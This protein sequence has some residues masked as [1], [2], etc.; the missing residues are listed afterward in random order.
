MVKDISDIEEIIVKTENNLP[1][2]IKDIAEVRFGKAIR[3]GAFTKNGEGKAVG[4]TVMMLKGF[5][6]NEVV[7]NVKAR[8]AEIQKTLPKGI[9]I[10][11]FLDRSSLI[12]DTTSTLK[13]NLAEG[14]LIVIFILILLL[15]NWRGG[16][17]VASTIPLSLLF[18]F[19]LMNMFG[20]S[21]NL[22]SLGA[23][24]FG[25]IV[26]GAVIIV[27]STVFLFHREILKK[28]TL[29]AEDR[30][31]ITTSASKKMMNSAFF[32]QIII[33]LVFVP[34]LFL[35]GIEGKMFRPM[36]FTFSFAMIGA[37]ILCLTYVPA[38]SALFLRAAKT[39]KK[40][41][42]DKIVLWLE[43]KY[44]KGLNTA[45]KQSKLILLSALVALGFSAFVF[46]KMGGEFIPQLDEGDIAFHIILQ[47][48]SSLEEATKAS[49]EVEKTILENFPEVT[50]VLC[51]FGVSEVP[52][53][54]M[55]MDL[56][57]C[58]AIL[59][60]KNEW[61]SADSK[62][63]L[64]NKI[65][66]K[67]NKIPG[68]SYEFTQPI[69]MRFNELISGVREDIAIKLYG[70][71]LDILAQKGQEISQIIKG[72]K[73]VADMKVEATSGLPQLTVK[74]NR[75]KLA[76][77]GISV[78]QINN[79]IETSF[80]GKKAGVVFEGEKRFDLV[81]RAS[82]KNRGGIK[83]V[84]NLYVTT[85]NGSQVPLSEVSDISYLP[86]PM[87]ISRD[88]TNRRISVGIN[89]RG[90]DIKSLVA[91]IEEKLD[92]QLKLPPGY[93]ISYGG[94]FENLERATE[95]LK[96]VVPLALGVIFI[97][98][99]F[100]L[101]SIKH[102]AIIYLAIPFAAIGGILALWLRDMPFSISAGIGFI[103][104]F[105][106]SVLNG[107]VLINSYKEMNYNNLK[108]N[109]IEGS[110]SRVRPILL[111]ALTDVLGFLPM[112]I[113]TSSGAEVQQ[114]LA[115]VV[116]GGLLTAS[117]LTL[118]ILPILYYKT[119]HKSY[120]VSGNIAMVMIACF[121]LGTGITQE[122]KAQNA[123]LPNT[124]TLEEAV[125]KAIDNYPGLRAAQ[126]EIEQAEALTK[127]NMSFGTTTLY[128]S[129]EEKGNAKTGV[130][131]PIGIQQN[132]IDLFSTGAKKALQE[133]KV[134]L[135]EDQ[136]ELNQLEV[137][138]A[139]QIDYANALITKKAFLLYSTL[140]STYEHFKKA[141]DLRLETEQISRLEWLST[142]N[143][144]NSIHLK[145]E[146]TN[147]E[148]QI[149]L[150]QLNK[151][152]NSDTLFRIDPSMN[153]ALEADLNTEITNHP[154]LSLAEQQVNISE[155]S[156]KRN[157]AGLNPTLN[158]MYGAQRIDQEW[159]YHAYQVGIN[160]PLFYGPQ[161][162]Q[163]QSS[164]IQKDVAIH[165]LNAAELE[166]KTK[167]STLRLNFE[168]WKASWENFQSEILP[169]AQEQ[170]FAVQ[171]MYEAGS[172]DFT[173]FI[174]YSQQSIQTELDGL[175]ILQSYLN[176][177]FE[178]SYYTQ[179]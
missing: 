82:K 117:L 39:E 158:V 135:A 27:E 68:V 161:K 25:I 122:T 45:L 160:V 37:I 59:K 24:D 66:A 173:N 34:I 10:V 149:A 3:Y 143:T 69:E 62:E 174:I 53:D 131:T 115:T 57:D 98:I 132:N 111:T 159:G 154:Y 145:K 8:I 150:L 110:K 42:G 20:V 40:S 50:Q 156:I 175:N 119:E 75:Y 130:V 166:L 29:N 153:I 167:L 114:P 137:K 103:V 23:I 13:T 12:E 9:Q 99:Y 56:A 127:G 142:Q 97:L 105:G 30:D 90:R 129:A 38:V 26:D 112:A 170:R 148:Y 35:E 46:T 121:V 89:V 165:Q 102:T 41:F 77:Y 60:P 168:K 91:E 169:N 125:K 31:S 101:G 36:A 136:L 6:S 87:Q 96:L 49:T 64:V 179:Q 48:G 74:H 52:T 100:A 134:K 120:S 2:R 138:K 5:N 18:A 32:G 73:G 80:A 124:I 155:A 163:I 67:V 106:V 177:Y 113:S 157:K 144:V 51:R 17:I 7:Q 151:W 22:M 164:K 55:P 128:N 21:A 65:K 70:D 172:V 83:D 44:E 162:A 139:V 81:L 178:L 72:T 118:F 95:R 140:D 86:G 109:I 61:V 88:N 141:S 171:R 133:S 94:A 1:I 14:G 16:L 43:S 93:R 47:P 78:E 176:A 11:P 123:P 92:A 126:L 152:F 63:E 147:K 76:Q 107:L 146:Q 71:D 79:L 85:A 19:I 104:L 15:G 54:P 84:E 33:L 4:G 108:D 58:F 116:I 28:H